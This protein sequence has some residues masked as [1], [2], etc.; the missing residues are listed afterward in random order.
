MGGGTAGSLLI[1]KVPRDV[2]SRER[3][4]EHKDA[5]TW[6]LTDYDRGKFSEHLTERRYV[7]F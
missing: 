6:G 7:F 1:P 5:G 4:T 3:S 2:S